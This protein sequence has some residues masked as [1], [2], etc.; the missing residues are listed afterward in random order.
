MVRVADHQLHLRRCREPVDTLLPDHVAGQSDVLE[1]RL[2]VL[3]AAAAGRAVGTIPD[4]P[5]SR[6]AQAAEDVIVPV[7]VL[8]TV[9]AQVLLDEVSLPMLAAVSV[10]AVGSLGVTSLLFRAGL[11]RYASASS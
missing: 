8:T 1:G 11:R 6:M 5:L 9:P 2:H 10:L 7:G 3:V 4:C